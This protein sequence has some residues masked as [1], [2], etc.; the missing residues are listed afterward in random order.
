MGADVPQ[1]P[2][3]YPTRGTQDRS[4]DPCG[5]TPTGLSPST[6]ADFHGTSGSPA[7]D[8]GL[9]P[10]RSYNPTSPV[11]LRYGIRFGLFRF[12]SPLLPES[13]VLSFPAGTE[14]FHFPAFP[15]LTGRSV[16]RPSGVSIRRSPDQRA[17]APPRG[18]SQLATAFI[19]GRAKASTGR[20]L[21]ASG[22]YPVLPARPA[23]PCRLAPSF[24]LTREPEM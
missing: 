1:I 23:Q 14:M 24:G 2:A 4:Q 16:L 18:L 21:R 15:P 17:P 20:R 8:P 10:G 7:R 3:R 5:L 6:A 22:V 13:L 12:R 19:G 9:R 11:P